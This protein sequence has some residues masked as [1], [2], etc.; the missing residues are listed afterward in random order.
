MQLNKHGDNLQTIRELHAAPL[1]G[2]IL[3]E[4]AQLRCMRS[5]YA[6][7]YTSFFFFIYNGRA[8]S[9][10]ALIKNIYLW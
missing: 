5:H 7:G 2:T 1:P 4:F 6:I 3:R 10:H 9:L 8:Q